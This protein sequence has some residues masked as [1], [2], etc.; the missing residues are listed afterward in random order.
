MIR[1]HWPT[2]AK[3]QSE[4]TSILTEECLK[5]RVESGS[6]LNHG[7][8]GGQQSTQ[9]ALERLHEFIKPIFGNEGDKSQSPKGSRWLRTWNRHLWSIREEII[10]A[11]KG[12]GEI[13]YH[14]ANPGRIKSFSVTHPELA[15]TDV[16]L[17]CLIGA[18]FYDEPRW[19][20]SKQLQISISSSMD[21]TRPLHRQCFF[22]SQSTLNLL[23]PPL[24]FLFRSESHFGRST[25]YSNHLSSRQIPVGVLVNF[26]FTSIQIAYQ[27]AYDLGIKK[28]T[29]KF[30]ATPGYCYFTLE[31]NHIWPDTI[32]DLCVSWKSSREASILC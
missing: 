31:E 30:M 7:I 28:H 14:F 32:S 24:A 20:R 15:D 10:L 6:G 4:Y 19:R 11:I 22:L 12:S 23:E 16:S 2:K 18:L 13:V 3:I 17:R 8:L 9:M 25:R 1:Q 27:G 21:L 5:Q 26:D 29:E